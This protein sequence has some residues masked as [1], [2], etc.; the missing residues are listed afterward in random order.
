MLGAP[1]DSLCS[2]SGKWV[3]GVGGAMQDRTDPPHPPDIPGT[4]ADLLAPCGPR[5]CPGSLLCAKVFVVR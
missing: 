5:T 2:V 4:L 1:R 3:A